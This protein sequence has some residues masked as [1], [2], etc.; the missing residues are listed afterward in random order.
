MMAN[1]DLANPSIKHLVMPMSPGL[2]E[3]VIHK[4]MPKHELEK[5]YLE[6]SHVAY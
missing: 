4:K 3:P 5:L 6:M 2:T 1:P